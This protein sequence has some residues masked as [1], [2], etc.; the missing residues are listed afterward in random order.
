MCLD[1]Q[2]NK[3]VVGSLRKNTGELAG[4]NSRDNTRNSNA[5][6]VFTWKSNTIRGMT[7]APNFSFIYFEQYVGINVSYLEYSMVFKI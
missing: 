6:N 1:K 3:S 7:Y 2:C 5:S 4:E